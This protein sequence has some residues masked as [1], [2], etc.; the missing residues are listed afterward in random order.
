MTQK[1]YIVSGESGE[2]SDRIQWSVA[3]YIDP[4][5]AH[6]HSE[7][8]NNCVKAHLAKGIKVK[9][10]FGSSTKYPDLE[11]GWNPFD[12]LV[13]E[14]ISDYSPPEYFVE[15]VDIFEEVPRL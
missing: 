2:Y 1:I 13:G 5:K 8:A 4:G 9:T 10:S 14:Y 7:L 11:K 6:L 15:S 12:P 3:A